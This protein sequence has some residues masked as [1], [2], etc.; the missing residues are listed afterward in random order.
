MDRRNLAIV[1][2]LSHLIEQGVGVIRVG[3]WKRAVDDF[4][5]VRLA[6]M[7]DAPRVPL[8]WENFRTKCELEPQPDGAPGS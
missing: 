1:G 6:S 5:T 3:F 8:R 4:L 2:L 7:A